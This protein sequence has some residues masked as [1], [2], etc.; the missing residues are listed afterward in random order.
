MSTRIEQISELLLEEISSR[1]NN[2]PLDIANLEFS[3]SFAEI[4]DRFIVLHIRMWKLE[5]AIGLTSSDKQVASL[6]RKID[7]CFKDRRPKL[8][9]AINS[10]LD[11]YISKNHVKP[12][13]EENVKFYGGFKND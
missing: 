12:F 10:F 3:E 9:K 5:D 1:F 4:I 11:S 7:Y 8:I 6:K 13:S 2:E